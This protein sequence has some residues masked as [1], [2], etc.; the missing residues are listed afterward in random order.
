MGES[1][2]INGVRY[3]P[4]PKHADGVRFYFMHDNHTFT[5]LR[6]ATLDEVLAHADAVEAAEGGS[7]GMLCPAIL[8]H[9]EKD[10]R[11]V[12]TP[13]H[14]RGREDPKD[15]WNAGKAKWRE[16]LEADID[17]MRLLPSNV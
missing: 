5:R 2:I 7:Y 4:D 17:V 3:I 14:A 11:R 8:I 15:N 12:G 9:G 6:G 10:V 16:A 13:A 1:V